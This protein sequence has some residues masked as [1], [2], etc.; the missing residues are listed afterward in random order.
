MVD[1]GRAQ[2]GST[3]GVQHDTAR[4]DRSIIP[5]VDVAAQHAEI[6][7]ELEPQ[8]LEVL[9]SGHYVGGPHVAAFEQSYAASVGVAHC[10]GVANGTDAIELALRAAGVCAGD[11]V[12]VPGNTFIATAEA[13][14]RIG[15]R[16]VPVDVD[17]QHLLMDPDAAAAAI[18]AR[19]RAIVPVH[20]FGQM[21]PMERLQNLAHNAGLALIEDAAQAQ[22]AR[23][24]G[25]AA[26]AW[27]AIAA[28][29][30]YP[31]KNLGA[32]GDGGA[33]TT[34]DDRLA[35]VVRM[36][37]N[38]GSRTKYQHEAVGVNS[39]LD[40]IHAVT[41]GVK[42]RRLEEW[43]DRRRA[44]AARYDD[45]LAGADGIRVPATLEGNLHAWHLY[46]VRV[47]QRDRV[48]AD[49]ADS[50]IEA[51]V[52]YPE[53]WY[54]SAAYAPDGY[55]RGACPVSEAAAGEILSLP[56]HPHLTPSQQ[57]R[58]IEALLASVQS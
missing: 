38:H 49:L 29:S 9:R 10:I 46:V 5:M 58:V 4:D 45:V 43:N 37:A 56:I 6:A 42:L 7:A 30:L 35:D 32:T 52:H 48:L 11:E 15:A 54:L 40:A 22:G 57:D 12:I 1:R 44:I 17:A 41:L 24:H 51:G 20:L 47:A 31:G 3:D 21:A 19:T 25:R 34:D 14:S 26:G 55:A 33:V 53:P 39:R 36:T 50:G 27:G 16:P 18:T 13:A 23:R 8:V 2:A 28:T